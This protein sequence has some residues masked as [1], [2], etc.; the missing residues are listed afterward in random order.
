[1]TIATIGRRMKKFDM[2]MPQFFAAETEVDAAG[3]DAAG[4]D[5]APDGEADA[6]APG[7]GAGL[8]STVAPSLIF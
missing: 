8:G 6:G 7:G 2:G 5:A 4:A 1:M 3:A